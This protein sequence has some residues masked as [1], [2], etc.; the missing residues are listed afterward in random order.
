MMIIKSL[1]NMSEIRRKIIKELC[2]GEN[3][4]DGDG[5]WRACNEKENGNIH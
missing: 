3:S 5:K 1:R 4:K 2:R